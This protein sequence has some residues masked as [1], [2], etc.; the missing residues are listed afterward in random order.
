M[1]ATLR[2]LAQPGRTVIVST[3]DRR[4]VGLADRIVELAAEVAEA[5]VVSRTIELGRGDVLFSEGDPADAVYLVERGRVELVRTAADGS[6]EVVLVA[7]AGGWFGELGPLLGF[8]RSATARART[9]AVV[10]MMSAAEFRRRHQPRR[11]SS[12]R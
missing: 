12:A 9:R 1:L 3:H 8:P 10:R 11:L 5:P 2:D 6:E 7:S 4:L